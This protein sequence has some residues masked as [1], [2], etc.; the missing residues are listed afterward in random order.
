MVAL[1]DDGGD[2]D[3]DVDGG[4]GFVEVTLAESDGLI[5]MSSI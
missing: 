1:E 3:G 2:I 4:A 5:G